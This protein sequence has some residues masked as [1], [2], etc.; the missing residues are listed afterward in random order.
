MATIQ[1]ATIHIFQAAKNAFFVASFIKRSVSNEMD[2]FSI[3]FVW[4]NTVSNKIKDQ[5]EK[6]SVSAFRY[7]LLRVKLSLILWSLVMLLVQLLI[8]VVIFLVMHCSAWIILTYGAEHSWL[9]VILIPA[10]VF[11][12]LCVLLGHSVIRILVAKRAVVFKNRFTKDAFVNILHSDVYAQKADFTSLIRS[13]CA[14]CRDWR[15]AYVND[16]AAGSRREQR[17][18]LLDITLSGGLKTLFQG[19]LYVLELPKMLLGRPFDIMTE[20]VSVTHDFDA[21]DAMQDPVFHDE[22]V[23]AYS[24]DKYAMY[25]VL[26]NYGFAG[27]EEDVDAP[28]PS[29]TA[30]QLLSNDFA[31]CFTQLREEYSGI[32]I[33]VSKKYMLIALG[34]VENDGADFFEPRFFDLF[35]SAE[36]IQKRVNAEVTRCSEVLDKI[37]DASHLMP[38]RTVTVNNLYNN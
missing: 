19:Q 35:R 34:G 28:G 25:D 27:G 22:F 38:E 21:T 18:L 14:I 10:V 12:I 23:I 4:N 2:R 37:I 1:G 9:P 20:I 6:A 7:S 26:R 3:L 17:F 29:F 15:T 31:N 13:S 11:V 24:K 16:Y 8:I 33:Q 5:D 36:S 32:F 30:G